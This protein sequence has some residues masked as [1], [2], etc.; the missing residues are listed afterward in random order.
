MLGHRT[1]LKTGY[2]LG[3][4]AAVALVLAPGPWNDATHAGTLA[5]L[6]LQAHAAKLSPWVAARVEAVRAGTS[7]MDV[8]VGFARTPGCRAALETALRSAAQVSVARSR[9]YGAMAADRSASAPNVIDTHEIALKFNEDPEWKRRAKVM[10]HDG[11]PFM[12]MPEGTNRELIVGITPHGTFG[13]SLK[14][15]TGQ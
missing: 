10:A 2:K 12:R 15:T 5:Q 6:Q 3:A 11:L 13:F 4:A 7:H 8:C 1:T 14:D 9:L